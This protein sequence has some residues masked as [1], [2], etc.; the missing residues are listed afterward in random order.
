VA[1]ARY[2]FEVVSTASHISRC[3][4]GILHRRIDFRAVT[5]MPEVSLPSMHARCMI[6]ASPK[7]RALPFTE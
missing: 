6:A 5:K 3:S 1:I 7:V 2:G 4:P